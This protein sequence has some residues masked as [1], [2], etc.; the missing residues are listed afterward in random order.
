MCDEDVRDPESGVRG[1]GFRPEL[2]SPLALAFLGD[3]VF[4]LLARER[5]LLEANRPPRAL[6]RES[7]GL[8]N[9]KEQ[10]RAME[11]LLPLLT[12]EELVVLRRGRNAKPAHAPPG[13]T[14]EEYAK[15]TALEALFGWLWLSG[16]FE[17][18]R[19]LFVCL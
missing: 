19:A 14:R 10:A 8:V 3:A 12:Q 5:L 17:R 1:K 6:H 2:Y 4:G 7:A 15:A 9:A 13:C 18:A 16:R 11:G